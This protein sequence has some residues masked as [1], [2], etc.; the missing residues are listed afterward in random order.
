M[1]SPR[2]T[3]LGGDNEATCAAVIGTPQRHGANHHDNVYDDEAP[4]IYYRGR[5]KTPMERVF[6]EISSQTESI[7]NRDDRQA[8][9]KAVAALHT[10]DGVFSGGHSHPVY[11]SLDM[12]HQRKYEAS[13][14]GSLR[15][16]VGRHPAR[17]FWTE[18]CR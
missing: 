1:R 16:L 13:R 17:T 14:L 11:G 10:V 8:R 9:R 2:E 18:G 4:E 3:T 15:T 5:F 6:T 7:G 12:S